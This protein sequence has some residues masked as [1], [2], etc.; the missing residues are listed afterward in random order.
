MFMMAAVCAPVMADS[1]V[2]GQNSKSANALAD[3]NQAGQP[4]QPADPTP[5]EVASY[6]K[7]VADSAA[8]KAT[9]ETIR[10]TVNDSRSTGSLMKD[11]IGDDPTSDTVTDIA[12]IIFLILIC[13]APFA[14]VVLIVYFIQRSRNL[15]YKVMEKAIEK[16]QPIPLETTQV[17][18]RGNGVLWQQGITKIGLGIGLVAFFYCL[19]QERIC[20]IGWLVACIGI[21]QVV[22][23]IIEENRRKR[24][25]GGN[26]INDT[27]GD[28]IPPAGSDTD[29]TE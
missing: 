14:M 26:D 3:G 17:K 23:G 25:S 20:G 4:T 13:L 19:G 1:P 16:G 28:S 29:K 15:K 18:S 22:A 10:R 27:A 2:K 12:G 5:S 21:G 7:A 11:L 6:T 9:A 8:K 24:L